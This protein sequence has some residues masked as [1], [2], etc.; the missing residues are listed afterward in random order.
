VQLPGDLISRNFEAF[1]INPLTL[2][3][4]NP[5]DETS[6]NS[7]YFDRTR[8]TTKICVI[9]A[10]ALLIAFGPIDRI[11][12]NQRSDLLMYSTIIRF[13]IYAPLVILY[14]PVASLTNRRFTQLYAAAIPTVVWLLWVRLYLGTDEIITTYIFPR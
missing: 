13:A 14:L 10:A 9:L 11:V 4:S 6:F 8:L 7:Q 2:R 5:N 3:F 1:G 12:Y